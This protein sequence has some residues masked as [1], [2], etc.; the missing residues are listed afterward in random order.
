MQFGPSPLLLPRRGSEEA[1]ALPSRAVERYRDFIKENFLP[2]AVKVRQIHIEKQY[3]TPCLPCR[4]IRK[5]RGLCLQKEMVM[6]NSNREGF[7]H[8]VLS[9]KN[10]KQVFS[11]SFIS[12]PWERWQSPRATGSTPQQEKPRVHIPQIHSPASQKSYKSR[13]I[14]YY[15]CYPN[16]H[17]LPF[18]S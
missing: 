9:K 4:A 18:F 14:K 10:K 12:R 7:T 17:L 15:K 16:I 2:K 11:T 13:A 5:K 8:Q 3:K 1:H 6:R